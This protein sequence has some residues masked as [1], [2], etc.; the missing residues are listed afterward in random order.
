MY[1]TGC[2]GG[3]IGGVSSDI[4]PQAKENLASFPLIPTITDSN[5][6]SP[7][8]TRTRPTIGHPA[9][10]HSVAFLSGSEI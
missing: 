4:L 3:A 5:P 9:A 1:G 10:S 7:S 2:G 8:C 6:N